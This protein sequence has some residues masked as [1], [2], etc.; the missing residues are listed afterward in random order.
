MLDGKEKPK[1]EVRPPTGPHEEYLELCAVATSGSLSEEE[2]KRLREHLAVCAAC[3]EAMKQFETVVDQ[4]IPALAPELTGETAEEDASFSQTAAETSF[5]KRLSEEEEKSRSHVGDAEPWLSPLVVR[6]SRNFRRRF[7]RY[8]LWLPMAAGLVL[9]TSLGILT[10][11]MGRHRGVDVARLE[12]G[13]APPGLGI[14]QEELVVARRDRDAAEARLAERDKAISEL[15]REIAQES[16]VNA[17]FQA[18]QSEQQIALKAS[19]EEKKQLAQER[20]G[21]AQQAAAGQAG[22]QASEKRLNGLER[23][24]SEDVLHAASL[25]AKVAELS[26]MVKD[27]ERTTGEQ[28]DLLAKDR[29]IRELMGARDLYIT[30]VYDVARTGETQKAFGRVFYT[31]GKSLVF[32]AY[33]L[34]DQPGLKE[35][36]TFEAWGRRGPDWTQAFKLGVFYEDNVSKKRWVLKSSDKKTL[37][38]LDA[39]FVTVEP[40]GGSERPTGKPLLFA[41]LKVAPNHP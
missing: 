1:D 22:L 35:A 8:H 9:C 21:F 16:S 5:F 28:Q 15:R 20:D 2:K 3:R 11:R 23:E 37:D 41:Y 38:Q 25:E 7:D 17:K 32:Y 19:E 26:G 31:R 6:R 10:Y 24:R 34:N 14:S 4:S 40:H 13:S 12:Q 30:E 39:V 18:I 29:D 33:D 36:S 27:Q